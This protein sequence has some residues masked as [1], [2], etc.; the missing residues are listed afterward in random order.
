MTLR[1]LA[2]TGGMSIL[3]AVLI[4]P[5]ATAQVPPPASTAPWEPVA[6][7][8]GGFVGAVVFDTAHPGVAFAGSDSAYLYRSTDGGASWKSVKVGTSSEGFRA[9][10]VSPAKPGTVYAYSTDNFFSGLGTLYRSVDD[11]RTWQPTPSQPSSAFGG[12][13]F[14]GQGR[15][16]AI[17]P[18]GQILVLTDSYAGILRSADGGATWTNPVANVR[19]YGLS[20]DPNQQGVLWAAGFD[21]STGL[22]SLWRSTDFGAT[23]TTQTPDAFN[24]PGLGAFAY[25]IAVQPGTGAIFASWSG[26]DP[27]TFASDGGIV[28]STDGGQT[29]SARDDGLLPDFSPG[30]A[31]GDIAFDPVHTQT[32]FLSTNGASGPG[33][34]Y[35]SRDRGHTWE[36]I[37]T[38][39]RTLAALGVWVRPEM[40]GYPSVLFAG[41][42]DLF[43][44]NDH[45]NHWEHS[46]L[47][48]DGGDVQFV[49]DDGIA[50]GGYYAVSS[51]DLFH[52]TDDAASWVRINTWDGPDRLDII[53]IDRNSPHHTIYAPSLNHL[54]RSTNAGRSWTEVTPAAPTVSGFGAVLVDPHRADHVY[55]AAYDG[56]LFFS[57]NAGRDWTS[58]PCG[59][60]ASTDGLSSFTLLRG[61]RVRGELYLSLLS[62]L[63]VAA[64]DGTSCAPAGVQPIPGGYIV[65][66]AEMGTNPSAL[67][68][69]G[70]PANGPPVVMRST[71]SGATYQP[72]DSLPGIQFLPPWNLASSPH[73][74]L[75]AASFAGDTVAV[76]RD[77]GANWTT[78]PDVFYDVSAGYSLLSGTRGKVFWADISGALYVA[79][80]EALH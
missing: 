22:P 79:P 45:G 10:A 59:Y 9:I 42:P 3:A 75:G 8:A 54:W 46:D 23:W 7:V 40:R 68:V 73:G 36:P 66:M 64:A 56:T 61:H 72:V 39:L 69:S 70:Y 62:G 33:G 15:G 13:F 51:A 34:I 78:Q 55:V 67:L 11:G 35:R 63:W 26:Q 47:G 38:A 76:S 74:H 1:E 49:A 48:L 37:G 41:T 18:T 80:D 2:L 16:I 32:I 24:P 27:N 58:V 25:S 53:G 21:R 71:D 28:V 14:P 20:K 50:S 6:R 17:D 5:C 57:R 77:G 52:S 19:A 43:V 60:G 30:V 4:V 29:W 12:A 65:S 31:S 44:S